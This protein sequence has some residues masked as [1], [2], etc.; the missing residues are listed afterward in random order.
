L[1]PLLVNVFGSE[2]HSGAKAPHSKVVP[3]L[4]LHKYS[5]AIRSL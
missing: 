3:E 5:I 1:A 4:K 2:Y